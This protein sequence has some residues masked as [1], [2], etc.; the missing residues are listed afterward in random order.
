[1]GN[2][3]PHLP[4]TEGFLWLVLV[5]ALQSVGARRRLEAVPRAAARGW[6]RAFPRL[7]SQKCLGSSG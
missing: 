4:R 3:A 2:G 1:M 6:G 5:S 7:S